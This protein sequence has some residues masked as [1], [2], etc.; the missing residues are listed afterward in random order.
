VPR[1]DEDG[2]IMEMA[3]E[4]NSEDSNEINKGENQNW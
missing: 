3:D 1:R 4:E 2:T